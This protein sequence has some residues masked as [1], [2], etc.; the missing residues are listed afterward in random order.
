V[1][2]I[3]QMTE[4]AE[5]V[6]PNVDAAVFLHDVTPPGLVDDF[7]GRIVVRLIAVLLIAQPIV[8]GE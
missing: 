8:G 5:G 6:R 2:G 7:T 1:N 3:L 4:H